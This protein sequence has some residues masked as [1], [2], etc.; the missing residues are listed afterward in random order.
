[1]TA[2]ENMSQCVRFLLF[3]WTAIQDFVNSGI[4][5]HNCSAVIDGCTQFENGPLLKAA[6]VWNV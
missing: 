5:C 2:Q 1:M 6:E 3:E 4:C